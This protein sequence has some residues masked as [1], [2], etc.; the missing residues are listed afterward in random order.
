MNKKRKSVSV[1]LIG[2]FFVVLVIGGCQGAFN[3][4]EQKGVAFV[5][6]TS[7]LNIAFAEDEPP[8]VVLDAAQQSFFITLRLK[9]EGEF[10]IPKGRLIGSLSGILKDVFNLRSLSVRNEFEIQGVKKE[11]DSVLA[12]G[13]ELLEFGEAV[14]KVDVP[15]DFST[16]I[17]ADVCYDY[18]TKALGN[19]CLKKNVL[20]KDLGDVCA[21]NAGE[22][23]AE[24][25]GAP[26]Q[27]LNLREHSVGTNRAKVIF[28]VKNV[29]IGAVF[30]PNIFT[31]ACIGHDQDK[32]RVKVTLFNPNNNFRV[33]CSQFGNTNS[34]VVR[35]VNGEKEISCTIDTSNLQ[36]ATFQD[37][38]IIQMDYM[39][40]D[41]VETQL[42]VKNAL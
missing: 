29:G 14:Y 41:A 36:E 25:S 5:G 19:L 8:A 33:E 37:L 31:D 38:L 32:D 10:T 1:V 11:G 40:R 16:K 6:G 34:G 35:L 2:L 15:A 12:G 26:V 3:K 13:E 27:V 22:I 18:Q 21:V 7:G 9:N 30:E 17:R 23:S 20:K 24:N 42:L 4:E 39:Y 28:K